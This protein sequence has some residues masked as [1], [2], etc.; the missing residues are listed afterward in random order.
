MKTLLKGGTVVSAAASRAAD[1][2]IEGEKILAVGENLP[3]DGAAV[4]DVAGKLLFPGFIDA[5]THFDLD[6]CSTTTADNFDTG[7]RSAIHGG[8]TLV[9][10]FACP[11]KGESLQYGLDLWHKKADGRSSCDY[12]FHMTIDDWNEAIRAEIPAMFAAGIPSFKMYMTYPAMMIGD[13]DMFCALQELKKYGGIAGVHCEN[14]G[15]IDALIAAHKAAGQTAPSSH[16]ALPP[17]PAGGRGRRAP[18]AHH[19]GRGRAHRDRPPEHE[20][21]LARGHARP[22]PRSAGLRRDLPALPAAR[23]QRVL[24][25]GLFRRR[26]LH[27]R[28][29]HA[30]EGGPGGPLE[31]AGQRHH[32][33]RL[34]R[35]LQLHPAAEGRRQGRLHEDPRRPARRGDARRAALY[36]GRGRR[37]HHEGAD[38]RP[39]VGKSRPPLRRVPA[40]GRDRPRQ[41]RGSSSSTTPQPTRPSRPERSFPP[42]ATPP[43]KAG[44]RRAPSRRSICAA[45]SPST[46]AR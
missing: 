44:G 12:G 45:R 7:T 36:R 43:T 25:G 28:A 40:Q 19:R 18:A 30:E 27:L 1:V 20:G 37:P 29:A 35:P 11:N 41:R 5:H 3:A 34:H 26:A 14:A 10:D 21:G 17:E 38:V 8:T 32:P 42:P 46:A 2:L 9:I 13:Q 4:V 31:G 6:V 24:P 15:V 39:A 23:R 33:D 22:R 16:P